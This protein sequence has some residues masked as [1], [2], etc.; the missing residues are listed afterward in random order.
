MS[1]PEKIPSTDEAWESGQL[2]RDEEFVKRL[3][4]D[5]RHERA[6]DESLGL[7]LISIRLPK[8]LIED[9]KLI[10]KLNGIG[11][12][13]LIRQVLLRFAEGEKRQIMR[14]VACEIEKRKKEAQAA[15]EKQKKQKVA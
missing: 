6:L 15:D 3:D 7:Q 2:G 12:Q 9:F 5:E 10:A 14:D 4:V 11:Y 1:N 13:P 8:A